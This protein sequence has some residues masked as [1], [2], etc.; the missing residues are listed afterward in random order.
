MGLRKESLPKTVR[1]LHAENLSYTD[2]QALSP[3]PCV[4]HIL[5]PEP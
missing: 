5:H 3:K 4:M 1:F 2:W